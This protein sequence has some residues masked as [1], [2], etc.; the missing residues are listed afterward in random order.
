MPLAVAMSTAFSASSDYGDGSWDLVLVSRDAVHF[1]VRLSRLLDASSSCFS[2]LLLPF[3]GQNGRVT[4]PC[5]NLPEDLHVLDVVL[6]VI[7]GIPLEQ[8]AAALETLLDATKALHKYGIPL[9]KHLVPGQMLFE[10]IALQTY[11]GALEVYAVAAEYDLFELASKASEHLLD[12]PLL[13]LPKEMISR[14]G[15][16]YLHMLYSL[17]L[18]RVYLLQRILSHSPQGHEP[19][20][21]CGPVEYRTLRSAWY[22]VISDF[23]SLAS[24]GMSHQWTIR[25]GELHKTIIPFIG[26]SATQ[27][28]VALSPLVS[29]LTCA[30]CQKIVQQRINEV[31]LRWSRTPVSFKQL[32]YVRLSQ[33]FHNT[34]PSSYDLADYKQRYERI[35]RDFLYVIMIC[36]L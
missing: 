13:Y 27:L 32:G 23:T 15:S 33:L 1:Y 28:R 29:T 35:L 17:H 31:V 21:F 26:V 6:H 16:A 3:F 36:I 9:D 34:Y 12:L 5:I 2:S 10:E 11:Q 4:H 24:P 20:A 8:P 30:E 7:Y 19:T 22:D 25:V 18:S 14:L